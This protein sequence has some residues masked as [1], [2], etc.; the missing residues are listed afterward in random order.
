MEDGDGGN[1]VNDFLDPDIVRETADFND[2][3]RVA[4]AEQGGR[5]SI[6]HAKL[7]HKLVAD[8]DDTTSR[9]LITLLSQVGFLADSIA[10]GAEN[11][12][13]ELDAIH[14]W[15]LEWKVD[16]LRELAR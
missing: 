4:C 14:G 15:V 12:L 5:D 13:D 10:N 11:L 6:N 2:T 1:A 16:Q 7:R 9:R 8:I 3:A